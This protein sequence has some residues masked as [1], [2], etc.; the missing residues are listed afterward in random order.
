MRTSL[1]RMAAV[2]ALAAALLTPAASTEAATPAVSSTAATP[3]PAASGAV[4]WSVEPAGEDGAP[5]GRSW[6]E[7]TLDA[8]QRVEAYMRVTNRGSRTATFALSAADGY[9][10]E[11]GRFSMLPAGQASA[12]AGTWITLADSVTIE[13]GA[14]AVV[15]FVVA[16]PAQATPGDHLA[17]VAAGVYSERDGVAVESRI[18]FRVMTRVTG[19]LAPAVA[20]TVSA[21]YA[22]SWNPFLPGRLT[23][24]V[25]TTNTGNTRLVAQEAV[26]AAGPLG[27]AARSALPQGL[28]ELAPGDVRRTTTVIDDVWP[29]FATTAGVRTSAT[30]VTDAGETASATAEATVGTPPWSQLGVL[31]AAAGLAVLVLRDRRRRRERWERR[32]EQARDEGRRAVQAGAA[33]ALV[34]VLGLGVPLATAPPAAAS[35]TVDVDITPRPTS[36]PFATLR[37]APATGSDVDSDSTLARTGAGVPSAL[38]VGGLGIVAAGIVLRI[39]G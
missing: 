18:G 23:V 9:F 12:D 7:L 39:R 32:L 36:S 29:T 10:T 24:V 13:P 14:S 16:V 30:G 20:S 37:P 27:V 4:S 28:P 1:T 3:V 15:P 34:V 8:G 19:E 25:T 6:I 2:V 33:L 17:G 26:T 22:P 5:D 31:L 38:I 21:D 11:E 35:A